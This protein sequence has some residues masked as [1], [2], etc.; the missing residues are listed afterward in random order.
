MNGKKAKA[1]RRELR[2]MDAYI[3]EN[4]PQE[5]KDKNPKY[6]VIKTPKMMQITDPTTGMPKLVKIEQQTLINTW[7]F[8]YRRAKKA[9]K[10]G[11]IIL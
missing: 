11:E 5:L 9:Y 6:K 7:K 8:T 2:A 3:D 10:N 1:L 4:S